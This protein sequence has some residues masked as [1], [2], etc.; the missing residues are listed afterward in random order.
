M[1]LIINGEIVRDDDPRAVAQRGRKASA[2]SQSG[3]RARG[4]Q[5]LHDPPARDGRAGGA[6]DAAGG[7]HAPPNY[8]ADGPLA[9]VA[10]WLGLAGKAWIIPPVP[11][12]NFQGNIPGK[13][14]E[15]IG[16]LTRAAPPRNS[17]LHQH[18]G[19][20]MRWTL[21]GLA[22][23]R[24]ALGSCHRHGCEPPAVTLL[25]THTHTHAVFCYSSSLKAASTAA[26]LRART[27]FSAPTAPC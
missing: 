23:W 20:W 9:P 14:A 17:S 10:Q 16:K 12:L 18:R 21:V 1:V 2:S 3:S 8:E 24:R 4:V 13:S 15:L 25:C 26:A 19:R 6:G 7:N 11:Q 27:L 22:H 5:T